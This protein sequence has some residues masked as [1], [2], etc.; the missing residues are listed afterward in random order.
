MVVNDKYSRSKTFDSPSLPPP[1]PPP[2][3]PPE[4]TRILLKLGQKSSMGANQ[5]VEISSK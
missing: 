2:L 5:R 1:P 3:P 4:S